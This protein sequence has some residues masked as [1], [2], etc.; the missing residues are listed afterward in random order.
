M[1][2][3]SRWLSFLHGG[4]PQSARQRV[5]ICCRRAQGPLT[6]LVSSPLRQVKEGDLNAF[7]S[8]SLWTVC[9]REEG[10]S[11][12]ESQHTAEDVASAWRQAEQAGSGPGA[13]MQNEHHRVNPGA[14]RPRCR[15]RDSTLG[16]RQKVSGVIRQSG[17]GH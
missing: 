5:T 7:S 14:A 4:T 10:L 3:R 8:Y 9:M 1:S 17:C 12:I 16:E 6:A 2:C 11:I 15:M 13:L